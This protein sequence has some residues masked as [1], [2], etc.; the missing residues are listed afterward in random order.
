MSASFVSKDPATTM[1]VSNR[2]LT[3][4]KLLRQLLTF[5][6]F[7]A[8]KPTVVV[9]VVLATA[10]FAVVVVVDVVVVVVAVVELL[11]SMLLL[12]LLLLLLFFIQTPHLGF[13]HNIV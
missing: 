6:R 2:S 11:I 13:Q 1:H 5:C 10:I 7:W 8:R 12:L 4:A 3:I 9:V